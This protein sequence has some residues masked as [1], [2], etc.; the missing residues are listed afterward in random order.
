MKPI[1]RSL[2]IAAALA[3][4]ALAHPGHDE[5]AAVHPFIAGLTHPIGGL[6][7]ILAMVAVGLWGAQRGGAALWAWPLSFVA[8]MLAGGA[9]GLSGIELPAIEPAIAASIVVLGLMVA[10]RVTVP[11]IGGAALIAAFALFHGNAHGLEAPAGSATLYAAGFTLS[12]ASLHAVGLALGL[13]AGRISWQPAIR[14]AGAIAAATG[15]SLFF[16]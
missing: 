9:L 6:D 2:I 1:L 12:T 4:A 5:L 7:H 10:F 13:A 14:I 15:A 3:P 11:V 8:I 16:A